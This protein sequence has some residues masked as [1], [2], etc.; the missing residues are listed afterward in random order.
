MA[1]AWRWLAAAS[2]PRD[3][4]RSRYSQR[5]LADPA[6]P[7]LHGASR[8][9]VNAPSDGQQDPLPDQTPDPGVSQAG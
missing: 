4:H 2:G 6:P 9:S 7:C 1:A 8:I 5:V 3:G